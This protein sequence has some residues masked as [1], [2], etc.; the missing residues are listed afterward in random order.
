MTLTT[1][2]HP[3]QNPK[4]LARNPLKGQ[5][6]SATSR[7]PGKMHVSERKRTPRRHL[8]AIDFFGIAPPAFV[9]YRWQSGL[10]GLGSD[11]VGAPGQSAPS[12]Y[13]GLRSQSLR[14]DAPRRA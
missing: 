1:L 4:N 13:A 12:G 11:P 8:E 6:P 2:H 10:V 14:G 7:N 9:S 5:H 3:A